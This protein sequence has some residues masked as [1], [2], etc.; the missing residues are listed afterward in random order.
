MSATW[1]RRREAIDAATHAALRASQRLSAW[2]LSCDSGN[3]GSCTQYGANGRK[4][5]AVAELPDAGALN[6]DPGAIFAIRRD[7]RLRGR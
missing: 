5:F 1:A 4:L 2:V 6:F 7:L 3:L